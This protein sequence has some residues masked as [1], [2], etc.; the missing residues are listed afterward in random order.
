MRYVSCGSNCCQVSKMS[1]W[2]LI[3]PHKLELYCTINKF[4]SKILP[5]LGAEKK[6]N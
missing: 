5:S 6:P 1:I 3:G 4:N 2:S